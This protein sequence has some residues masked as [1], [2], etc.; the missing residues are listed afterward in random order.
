MHVH[1]VPAQKLVE[2]AVHG[3]GCVVAFTCVGPNYGLHSRAP[4]V[5]ELLLSRAAF[6]AAKV[7]PAPILHYGIGQD[8]VI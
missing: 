3:A 6:S 5:L 2:A 7:L 8:A 4:A 1:A